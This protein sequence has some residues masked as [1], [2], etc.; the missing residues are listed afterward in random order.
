MCIICKYVLVYCPQ[1]PYR[2]QHYRRRGFA[3]LCCCRCVDSVSTREQNSR[4]QSCFIFEFTFSTT[5]I[6]QRGGRGTTVSCKRLHRRKEQHLQLDVAAQRAPHRVRRRWPAAV[7][8]GDM[9]EWGRGGASLMLVWPVR[10]M[11]RRSMPSPKPAV[12]GS[13]WSSA[14]QK[15][16]RERARASGLMSGSDGASANQA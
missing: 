8:L 11:V 5:P 16:C 2:L 7:S 4:A 12:G 13:A 6:A 14:T 10:S 1:H 9:R 15:P 3:E